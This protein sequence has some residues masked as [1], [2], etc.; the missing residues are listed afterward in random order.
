MNIITKRADCV[1]VTEFVYETV[2]G[3]GKPGRSEYQARPATNNLLAIGRLCEVLADAGLITADAVMYVATGLKDDVGRF[4]STAETKRC[5]E[6]LNT[7]SAVRS[8]ACP[9]CGSTDF[10]YIGLEQEVI[11]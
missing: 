1:T 4:E 3:A 2:K 5:N 8:L 9:Y 6:C 7:M 11:P 10:E